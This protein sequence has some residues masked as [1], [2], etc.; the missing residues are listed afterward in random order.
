MLC[1]RLSRLSAGPLDD[2][3][4]RTLV[5]ILAVVSIA[6]PSTAVASEDF[7][8]FLDRF[9]GDAQFRFERT[10][11]MWAKIGCGPDA[12]E[13]GISVGEMP[14]PFSRQEIADLSLHQRID[15]FV[16]G[17]LELIQYGDSGLQ[18]TY[19]FEE[20]EGQWHLKGFVDQKCQ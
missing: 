17:E 1:V 6:I 11:P 14:S 3:M 19:T 10:S 5:S 20:R 7:T 16:E 12:A 15:D 8:W 4:T 18:L 2:L 13:E 9:I